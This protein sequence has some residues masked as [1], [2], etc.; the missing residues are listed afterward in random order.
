MI[1]WQYRKIFSNLF[2]K[3][4]AVLNRNRSKGHGCPIRCLTFRIKFHE[5]SSEAN[6]GLDEARFCF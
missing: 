3:N 4:I 1:Y 5:M 2:L 6:K